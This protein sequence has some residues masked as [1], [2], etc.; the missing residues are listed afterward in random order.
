MGVA[1]HDG[2]VYMRVQTA[3]PEGRPTQHA[4]HAKM[5]RVIG[6]AMTHSRQAA[7]TTY[8]WLCKLHGNLQ[9]LGVMTNCV[10]CD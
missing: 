2:I 5:R 7:K 4:L 3:Q 8:Q 9:H 6:L 10:T 1:K